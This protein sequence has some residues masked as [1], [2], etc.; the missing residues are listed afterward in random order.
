MQYFSSKLPA[1]DSLLQ[2]QQL[3]KICHYYNTMQRDF[4]VK[5]ISISHQTNKNIIT[6]R[7]SYI[8]DFLAIEDGMVNLQKAWLSYKEKNGL[9]STEE[10]VQLYGSA[11]SIVNLGWINCDR[12][13]RP[14]SPRVDCNILVE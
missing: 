2:P 6:N 14:S 9:L 8:D 13:N 4:E 3:K 7:Q 5:N 10:I 11:L 12:F 1:N